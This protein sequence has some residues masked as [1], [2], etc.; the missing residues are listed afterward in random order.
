MALIDDYLTWLE[1]NRGRTTTT[2]QKY[3]RYLRLLQESLTAQGVTLETAELRHLERFTGLEAHERGISPRSR[4]PIVSAVRGFYHW[5]HQ[6]GRLNL[7]PAEAI[8]YP[9]AG[10]P[11]PK[12]L[13]LKQAEALLMAPPITT[14]TGLR[15]AAI[16]AVLIGCGLRVTGVCNLNEGDLQW[17][18]L[19]GQEW[20]VLKV[21]EKGKKERLVPAPQE[22]RLLIRA[23]LGHEKLEGIDRVLPNG[24]KVLFVSTCSN[25][26]PPHEYYGENRRISRKTIS[27]MILRYGE[28]LGI[29]KDVLH[30]H[31]ARH[32]YGTELAEEGT[33]I[34]QIQALMG[35]ADPKT[36]SVYTHLAMRTLTE[37]VA[38]ANPLSKILT[39][40]SDL[41]RAL[42]R[43]PPRSNR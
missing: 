18:Q 40:V 1:H 42:A 6:A 37:R 22:T 43:T 25:H 28:R 5:A 11:L 34:L 7:N 39:P 16:L 4:T 35:H 8:P 15:D 17:V 33:N 20:L 27:S 31:A 41:A 29:P 3:G 21:R 2:V 38:S 26:V 30:P 32:L 10:Q 24:D 36:C 14:F 13:S 23:Y 9:R 12:S 19:R